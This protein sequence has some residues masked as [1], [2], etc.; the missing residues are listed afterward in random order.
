LK[1]L[2]RKGFLESDAGKAR[3]LRVTSPLAKLRNRIVDILQSA[4]LET[5]RVLA[6][7]HQGGNPAIPTN[8]RSP[9]FDSASLF[10]VAAIRGRVMG[11]YPRETFAKVL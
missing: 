5:M 9:S 6:Y 3:S 11:L 4:W 8:I 1:A 2:K 10:Q 7:C